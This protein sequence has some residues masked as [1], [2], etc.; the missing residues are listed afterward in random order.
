METFFNPRSVAVV[1][2]SN[3]PFNLGST[4]C[5][6]L[7]EFSPWKPPETKGKRAAPK[8]GRGHRPH[9]VGHFKNLQ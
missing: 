7:K 5:R 3:S 9:H 8:G 6:S 1:G 4:I 2:A